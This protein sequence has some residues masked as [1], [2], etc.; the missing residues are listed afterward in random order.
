LAL[1]VR[2]LDAGT[3]EVLD[4]VSVRKELTGRGAGISGTGSLIG[5]LAAMSGRTASPLIPDVSYQQANND[6]VDG[7]LRACINAA[8]LQLVRSIPAAADAEIATVAPLRSA[9]ASA[10]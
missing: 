4:S 5:T 7:A 1:D 6:S 8:V 2:I 10:P 9:P 3:G